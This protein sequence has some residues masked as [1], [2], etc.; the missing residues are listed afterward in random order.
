MFSPLVDRG[1]CRRCK[2]CVG[3]CPASSLFLGA[4]GLFLNASSCVSCGLCLACCPE[5]A[6]SWDNTPPRRT[7][8]GATPKPERL[9]EMIAGRLWHRHF[10]GEAVEQAVLDRVAGASR[11]LPSEADGLEVVVVAGPGTLQPLQAFCL[12][13][14]EK[15]YLRR[16][17]RP[18]LFDLLKTVMPSVDDLA[19]I[20]ARLALKKGSPFQGASALIL[21]IGDRRRPRARAIVPFVLADMLLLAAA[22]GLEACPSET[23]RSLLDRERR[24][25]KILSL[26]RRKRIL[27]VL[28][29]GRPAAGML[30]AAGLP[31][32]VRRIGG[33]AERNDGKNL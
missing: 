27:G 12:D 14:L 30:R 2:T 28:L 32:A 8:T 15:I 11:Q 24:A 5:G 21:V 3:A 4:Q 22:L 10:S 33:S 9:E 31:L 6:I 7:D 1:A 17:A 20:R 13:R 29:V 26:P 23:A 19:R 18:W 16:Y 25:R